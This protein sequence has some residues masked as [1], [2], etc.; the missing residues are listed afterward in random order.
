[1]RFGL[2]A[3]PAEEAAEIPRQGAGE[4]DFLGL[5]WNKAIE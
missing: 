5:V 4:N 2:A 1:M 3:G